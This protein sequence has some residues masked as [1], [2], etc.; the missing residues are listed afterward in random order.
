MH[1]QSTNSINRVSREPNFQ[2]VKV[3]FGEMSNT[4]QT[5]TENLLRP[6]N[7]KQNM[8]EEKKRTLK[9]NPEEI[10]GINKKKGDEAREKC[11]EIDRIEREA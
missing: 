4:T 2:N 11:M 5:V 7:K 10:K 9:S 1:L 8:S 6:D 3:E